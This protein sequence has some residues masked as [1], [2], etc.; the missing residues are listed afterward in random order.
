MHAHAISKRRNNI[1]VRCSFGGNRF[2]QGNSWKRSWREIG[3]RIYRGNRREKISCREFR[4]HCTISVVTGSLAA[5]SLVRRV[6]VEGPLCPSWFSVGPTDVFFFPPY[7]LR[8]PPTDRP[9]HRIPPTDRPPTVLPPSHRGRSPLL[10]LLSTPLPRQCPP[11]RPP[12]PPLH[13]PGQ[14]IKTPTSKRRLWCCPT[15]A[16]TR[17][18]CT[19]ANSATNSFWISA[20]WGPKR[21]VSRKPKKRE[22]ILMKIMKYTSASSFSLSCFLK[23]CHAH[24]SDVVTGSFSPIFPGRTGGERSLGRESLATSIPRPAA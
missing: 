17:S 12:P 16:S 7:H 19:R 8:A 10:V 24:S 6:V 2:G 14:M 23:L 22:P 3:Q 5:L 4:S 20:I 15:V 11:C 13:P 1:F 9:S 21:A 18:R